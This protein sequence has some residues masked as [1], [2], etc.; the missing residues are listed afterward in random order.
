MGEWKDWGGGGEVFVLLVRCSHAKNMQRTCIIQGVEK[1][2]SP[3]TQTAKRRMYYRKK[4]HANLAFK[5]LFGF[6][7]FLILSCLD[8]TSSWYIIFTPSD[9]SQHDVEAWM[10]VI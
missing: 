8:W 6:Y 9:S 4:I 2:E 5:N 3:G 7:S 1:R 10:M